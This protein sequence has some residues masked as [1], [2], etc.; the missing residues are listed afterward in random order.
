M[1]SLDEKIMGKI[2]TGL[3]FIY[4]FILPEIWDH[5]LE[6]FFKTYNKICDQS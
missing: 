6:Y 2:W 1:D 5:F 3:G 4:L